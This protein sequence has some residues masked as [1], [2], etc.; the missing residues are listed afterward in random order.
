MRY[1]NAWQIIA[2]TV[3]WGFILFVLR[4]TLNKPVEQ[5]VQGTFKTPQVSL[6]IQHVGC[7]EQYNEVVRALKTLPWLG[8][9]VVRRGQ[10]LAGT[11]DAPRE[12]VR[13]AQPEELCAARVLAEVVNVA[14]ADLVQLANTL[15]DIG[16][17]P[18]LFEFGGL[19]HFMLRAKVPDLSCPSCGRAAMDALTPLPVSASYYL[20]TTV[21]KGADI[22]T[23]KLTTFR[24]LE[25]KRVDLIQNTITASVK[26]NGI[27]HVGEMLRAL[28]GAGLLPLSIRIVVGEA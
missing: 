21:E 23:T 20:S 22:R 28:E 26:K 8:E 10:A 7:N 6:F 9:P 14:Q 2:M 13:P 5:Q 3:V 12:P 17:V 16:I 24:W 27:V 18:A 4:D 25:T 15:R 19:P 11:P 1:S